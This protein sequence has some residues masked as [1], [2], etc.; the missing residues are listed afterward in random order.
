MY[1]APVECIEGFCSR[2]LSLRMKIYIHCCMILNIKVCR[3]FCRTIMKLFGKFLRSR[4][5]FLVRALS[6]NRRCSSIVR[7][8][9]LDLLSRRDHSIKLLS[10][11]ILKMCF[12]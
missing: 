6:P 10:Y 2:T 7:K 4:M 8:S 12:V 9:G 1:I 11:N 5:S 3:G